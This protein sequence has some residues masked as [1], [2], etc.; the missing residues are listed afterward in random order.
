M[1]SYLENILVLIIFIIGLYILPIRIVGLNFQ[2]VPGDLGD[3][4]FNMVILEHGYQY[5][6]G[7]IGSFWDA[8]YIY[9]RIDN[10]I[11]RSDNLLGTMPI[12]AAFRIVGYE[13]ITSFQLWFITLHALN[14]IFCYWA[15]KK[16]F[17][18]SLIAT[19]S[20]YVFAF[21]I[22]NLGQIYHAQIFPRFM[23]P[24]IFY[25]TIKLLNESH[26]KYFAFLLFGLVY[27]FYCGIYL[28]FFAIYAL[29]FLIISYLII[30]KDFTLFKGLKSAKKIA[31]Y[32]FLFALTFI[33]LKVLFAP[34]LIISKEVG[35][36]SYESIFDSIPYLKS[37]F[38]S[39]PASYLWG[40]VLY[41]PFMETFEL[42]WTHFLFPGLIPILSIV[43][44]VILVVFIPSQNKSKKIITFLLLATALSLLFSINFNGFSLY[45]IIYE[46]PGFS[47]MRAINR[48]INVQ[49][50]FFILVLSTFLYYLNQTYKWG[51]YLIYLIL[52]LIVFD[53]YYILNYDVRRFDKSISLLE[54]EKFEQ[55][56]I[57][58]NYKAFDAVAV[59]FVNNTD[60]N[61]IIQQH[62]SVMIACQNLGIKCVNGYS[63]SYPDSYMSFFDQTDKT[64]LD[65]WLKINKISLEK[66]LLINE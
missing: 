13:S 12:Y 35:M 26:I 44:S 37:Y 55:I 30:Y 23:L 41:K 22:F 16:L 34:Y 60:H 21:G 4:R 7:K 33:F 20:A 6:T 36:R 58:S 53:N 28:G 56:I 48:I 18:N 1:K 47:S 51:K 43:G 42:W 25:W 14:F 63:G 50:V 5:L 66:V 52:P 2:F 32:L 29:L 3:A 9:P 17:N 15:I 39:N 11:A 57:N 40:Q 46:I 24:L 38:F 10:L 31:Q 59:N 54:V 27:Q 61:L 62:I 65:E 8:F 45:G 49:V 19:I 64:T